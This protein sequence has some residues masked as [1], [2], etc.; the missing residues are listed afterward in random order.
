MRYFTI[1]L[2]LLAC[3]TLFVQPAFA[4][5]VS[6]TSTAV[7]PSPPTIFEMGDGR[8]YHP[9]TGTFAGT[10]EELLSLLGYAT[11]A[12]VTVVETPPVPTTTPAL[13]PPIFEAVRRAKAQLQFEIQQDQPTSSKPT[14]LTTDTDWRRVTIALWNQ[15]TDEMAYVT[16]KKKGTG[17]KCDIADT[18]Y[19]RLLRV[20]NSR[21]VDSEYV[22][23]G[24]DDLRVV[25]VRYPLLRE[26]TVNKKKRFLQEEVVYT[27][28]ARTLHTADVVEQGKKFFDQSM[29]AALDELRAK[30][31]V[32]RAFAGK[33]V[34]D[35]TDM[36]TLTTVTA[37]EHL[38]KTSATKNAANALETFYVTLAL[39]REDAYRFDLSPAGACGI[40]Q[41]MPK[42][43]ASIAKRPELELVKDFSTGTKQPVNMLKAQTAYFDT[44]LSELPSVAR[45]AYLSH[46]TSAHEYIAAAYNGG[47]SRVKKALT[48]W[49]AQV[50]NADASA[51]AA[52]T[53]KH[54]EVWET[55]VVA[56]KKM[57]DA[58][59]GSKSEA[60]WKKKY[61]ALKKEHIDLEKKIANAPKSALPK[62]TRDYV[63]K[64]RTIFP[65]VTPAPSM[66]SAIE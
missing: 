59:V 50:D 66:A 60:T 17:L 10:R 20:A 42:T 21:G 54:N 12:T 5:E 53:K 23:Q 38:D 65:L 45:E 37:I 4:E 32:S 15:A 3:T 36:R 2:S 56:K 63:A 14:Y 33:L 30:Q 64:F 51:K 34:A 27:P 26:V 49:D 6:A 7:I 29:Q 18:G 47:T 9:G 48:N 44:V 46:A 62:E 16:A 24:N 55:L 39:N 31:V 43:Y 58:P 22:V 40:A 13:P 28:Y 61:L 52:L 11:S 35:T 41:F 8:F 57:I 1:F 19:C 25:A